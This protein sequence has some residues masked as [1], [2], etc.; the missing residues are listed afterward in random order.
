MVPLTWM[1]NTLKEMIGRKSTTTK[2]SWKD[3]EK[4][5]VH[6]WIQQTLKRKSQSENKWLF[7]RLRSVAEESA[8]LI[9]CGRAF[10]SLGAELQKALKPRCFLVCFSVA[11]GTDSITAKPSAIKVTQHVPRTDQLPSIAVQ[12]ELYRKRLSINM[13]YRRILW[14]KK[15]LRVLH[16]QNKCKT[17]RATALGRI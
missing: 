1:L 4:L 7:R 5:S 9:V 10:Q 11:L 15:G 3:I 16:W 12:T 13:K 6:S 14:D 8:A 2:K 17:E